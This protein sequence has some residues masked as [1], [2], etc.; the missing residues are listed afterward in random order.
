MKKAAVSQTTPRNKIVEFSGAESHAD[1]RLVPLKGYRLLG[2]LVHPVV[3]GP[4]LAYATPPVIISALFEASAEN[5][6]YRSAIIPKERG[7][8]AIASAN[9]E[10][11]S[12]K[13]LVPS[14]DIG[15]HLAILERESHP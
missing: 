4:P 8:A 7:E 12:V 2:C 15:S 11:W 5:F 1:E 6:Q 14:N 9:A 10:N 3:P 13:F